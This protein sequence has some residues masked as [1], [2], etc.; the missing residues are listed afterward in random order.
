MTMIKKYIS[1]RAYPSKD[2][3][4]RRKQIRKISRLYSKRDGKH[5]SIN[6]ALNLLIAETSLK[7]AI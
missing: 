2:Y 4:R 6:L 5:I 1:L 3:D 7:K